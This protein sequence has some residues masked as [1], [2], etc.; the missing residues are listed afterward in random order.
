M[1][2]TSVLNYYNGGID[3]YNY[4]IYGYPIYPDVKY[5][6]DILGYKQESFVSSADSSSSEF[7]SFISCHWI[8][9]SLYIDLKKL[10]TDLGI[11]E[12]HLGNIAIP[13]SDFRKADKST[14]GKDISPTAEEVSQLKKL[15]ELLT[16]QRVGIV[17]M[18]IEVAERLQLDDEEGKA[19]IREINSKL[20]K[21]GNQMVKTQSRHGYIYSKSEKFRFTSERVVEFLQDHIGSAFKSSEFN[22][23]LSSWDYKQFE[24]FS[25]SKER[26]RAYRIRIDW[27]YR[28]IKNER[29]AKSFNDACR[30]TGALFSIV[31]HTV[32]SAEFIN[33]PNRF[34]GYTS[35]NSYL[36]DIIK[37][38]LKALGVDIRSESENW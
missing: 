35:Y 24:N 37:S 13:V 2:S 9:L 17:S 10:I 38:D 23:T 6:E 26:K 36:S 34:K 22:R 18:N 33:Q 1:Q 29:I 12:K 8:D 3:Y 27:L 5:W 25:Y 31:Q 16:N 32:S 14:I 20:V 21:S 11:N 7:P 19:S 4:E 28:Y 15:I 30:I